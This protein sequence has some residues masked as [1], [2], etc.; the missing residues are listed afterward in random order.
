MRR[1]YEEVLV[2]PGTY[3]LGD[4][5]YTVP[6]ELWHALLKDANFFE[7]RVE[8]PRESFQGTVQGHTVYAFGTAYGD[9]GYRGTDGFTYSVDAGLVGLVPVELADSVPHQYPDF[10]QGIATKIVLEHPT[11]CCYNN[12]KISL[13]LVTIDTDPP[14]EEEEEYNYDDSW[15]D[16]NPDE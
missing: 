8:S 12:G 15:D 4:P 14:Y 10:S 13:G 2:Q 3:Y 5:C 1:K 7:Y 6:D 11:M 9:G 16:S